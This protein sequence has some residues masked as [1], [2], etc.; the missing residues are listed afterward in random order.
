[1]STRPFYFSRRA[2][3]PAHESNWLVS[4][5][6]MADDHAD[7]QKKLN[8]LLEKSKRNDRGSNFSFS[9]LAAVE[10]SEHGVACITMG[11]AS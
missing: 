3:P 1:M 8:A 11:N 4:G 5:V 6:V 10:V 2:K 9:D 7:A